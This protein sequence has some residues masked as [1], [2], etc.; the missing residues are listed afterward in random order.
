MKNTFVIIGIVLMG[1]F[2]GCAEKDNTFLITENSVGPLEKSSP[3]SAI[4]SI[5]SL[6]SIV[7]DTMISKVGA[8]S[9]KIQIFEKDGLPLLVLTPNTDSIPSAENMQILD[10]R[11]QTE[12]GIGLLSTF[13]DIQDQYTIKKIVTTLNS[14]VVFPKGSNLYFTIDK[15]ELPYNLR[16]TNSKIEAVQIPDEAKI[17]YLMLS[18]D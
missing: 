10:Y 8:S 1:F 16:Y 3:I 15:T 18:W 14:L 11:Y 12:N 17:K 2:M 4:E 6:D 9:N 5:F 13:K 7:K